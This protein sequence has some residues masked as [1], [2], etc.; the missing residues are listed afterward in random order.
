MSDESVDS[1]SKSQN[2]YL[3]DVFVQDVCQNG[4]YVADIMQILARYVQLFLIMLL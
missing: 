1:F 2:Q 3:V 4:I